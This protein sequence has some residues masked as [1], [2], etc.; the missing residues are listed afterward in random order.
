MLYEA[1][2]SINCFSPSNGMLVCSK[3]TL[4]NCILG[5]PGADSGDKRKSKREETYGTKKSK[6]RRSLLFFVP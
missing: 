3:V 6:E 2:S 1:P 5:D 4:R